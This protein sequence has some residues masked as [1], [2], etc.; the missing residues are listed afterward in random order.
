MRKDFSFFSSTTTSLGYFN[1]ASNLIVSRNRLGLLPSV[2]VMVAS[3][4]VSCL[5]RFHGRGK[6]NA[7]GAFNAFDAALNFCIKSQSKAIPR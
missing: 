3:F 1:V 7:F 5:I 2:E 6:A 4:Y